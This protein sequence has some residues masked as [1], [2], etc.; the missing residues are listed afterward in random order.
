MEQDKYAVIN[1]KLLELCGYNA[2]VRNQELPSDGV[3]NKM[4]T[5][6]EEICM[7]LKEDHFEFLEMLVASG[8]MDVAHFDGESF[9]VQDMNSI[10]ISENNFINLEAGD[11]HTC[12]L[13]MP[14]NIID[15]Y[16][17]RYD[18]RPVAH[19]EH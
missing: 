11:I 18:I 10:Y 4:T 5:L 8:I 9:I 1:Q 15:C 7:M 6:R 19:V 17:D 3:L 12:S 16:S 13:S 14:N 2:I